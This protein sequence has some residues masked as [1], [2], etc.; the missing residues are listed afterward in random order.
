MSAVDINTHALREWMEEVEHILHRGLLIPHE[1][2]KIAQII[3]DNLH[4]RT[5]CAVFV[6]EVPVP[7]D[8]PVPSL[9]PWYY[10][11]YV[12]ERGQRNLV[13]MPKPDADS[14]HRRLRSSFEMLNR[15]AHDPRYMRTNDRT[16]REA[17][18]RELKV[19]AAE[20]MRAI[21]ALEPSTP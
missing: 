9:P 8:D 1:G 15:N 19:I 14:I 13:G 17:L 18:S 20:C 21:E 7:E 11:V 12:L 5:A 6:S 4:S 16:G 3:I 2:E 10:D